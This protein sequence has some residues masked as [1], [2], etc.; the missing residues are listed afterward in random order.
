[1]KQQIHL[2]SYFSKHQT[3]GVKLSELTP[4]LSLVSSVKSLTNL[5]DHAALVLKFDSEP[6]E[7]YLIEATSN[8]GVQL[9]KWREI[10]HNLGSFYEKIAHRHL[11][12]ERPDS[13]IDL[14]EQFINET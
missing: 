6:N 3:L 9:K 10:K 1:M 2:T 11:E 8:R 5:L 13:S 14:L 12:W 7:V 4:D